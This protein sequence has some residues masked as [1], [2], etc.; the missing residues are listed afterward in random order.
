MLSPDERQAI[1]EKLANP[2]PDGYRP[3]KLSEKQ[4]DEICR[5]WLAG[6]TSPAIAKIYGVRPQTVHY[7]VR[8]AARSVDG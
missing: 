5:L 6:H 3:N 1:A 7:H 8:R 4:R 2:R